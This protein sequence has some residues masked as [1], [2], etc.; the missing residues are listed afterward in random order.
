MAAIRRA[1]GALVALTVLVVGLATPVAASTADDFLARI[2]GERMAAGLDPLTLRADL[3]DDAMAHSER[4]WVED[5]L[6]HNPALASVATGWM[7]LGENV[8]VG[9]SVGVLHQAFMDSPGHRANVLG[10]YDSIGVGVVTVSDDQ[11]WVTMVFMKSAAAPPPQVP[12]ASRHDVGAVVAASSSSTTPPEP[13]MT[14]AP[15]PVPAGERPER[16]EVAAGSARPV[17]VARAGVHTP[18]AV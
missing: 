18:V 3:V 12:V 17:V 5:R 6:Y 15:G 16:T 4:M 9:P 2:N 11:M 7:S 1:M 10:D 14:P 13:R 8:G